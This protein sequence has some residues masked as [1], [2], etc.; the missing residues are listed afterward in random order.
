MNNVNLKPVVF[1]G[2]VMEG[3]FIEYINN[4]VRVWSKKR[5]KIK[6]L[7]IPK[8]GSASYPGF[9]FSFGPEKVRA[10]VHRVIAENIIAFPKPQGITQKDWKA[11]PESIKDIMKTV[12]FVNHI[13]HDKYNCDVT[14]LEWVTPKGNSHAYQAHKRASV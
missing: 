9:S 7:S 11:T 13:D 3:Y 2:V 14:N 12:F 1:G 5:S 10:D 6:R 4:E 8:S